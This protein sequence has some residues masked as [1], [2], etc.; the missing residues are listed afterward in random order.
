MKKIILTFGFIAIASF[1]FAQSPINKGQLQLNAGVGFS[2]WGIPIYVGL[3][4]GVHPDITVGGEFSFRTYSDNFAGTK[5]SHSIIGIS[6][7][8]NYHF[9]RLLNIP[10]DW[11]FYAGLNLGFYFWNSNDDYDGSDGSGIGLGAQ[12]GGRY[13]FSDR[14]GINLELGGGNTLSGGKFGIT[15]KF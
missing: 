11:D 2:S 1:I 9:N 14:F 7:N 3:D 6:G 10:S 5:Y 8:G 13:Y 12:I 15:Y 4:Y